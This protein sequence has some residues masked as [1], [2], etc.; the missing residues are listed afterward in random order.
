MKDSNEGHHDTTCDLL[1]IGAFTLTFAG[2]QDMALEEVTVEQ[3]FRFA[4][5]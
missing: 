1:R 3:L 4:D 2:D 5:R